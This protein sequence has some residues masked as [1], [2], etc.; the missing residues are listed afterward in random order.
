MKDKL[1]NKFKEDLKNKGYTDEDIYE[2]FK[3]ELEKVYFDK[4]KLTSGSIVGTK[5]GGI[6]MYLEN[7]KVHG[8]LENVLI[9]LEDFKYITFS[10]YSNNLLNGM[11]IFSI[12]NICDNDYVGDNFRN[13]IISDTDKWTAVRG[14][15][16][17]EIDIDNLIKK[18]TKIKLEEFDKVL[19]RYIKLKEVE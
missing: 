17:E 15:T 19:E 7:A 13:H 4:N 8:N 3:E 16:Q 2:I 10:S 9:N 5:N 12:I 1:V 18:E 14:K 11:S 6:Y